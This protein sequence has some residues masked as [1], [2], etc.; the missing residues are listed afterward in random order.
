MQ[1]VDVK[2]EGG[3]TKATTKRHG[4]LGGEPRARFQLHLHSIR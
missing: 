3:E 4:I 1:F 2:I